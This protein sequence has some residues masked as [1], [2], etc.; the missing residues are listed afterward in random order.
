MASPA[1]FAG[2]MAAFA[3]STRYESLF[4]MTDRELQKRGYDRGGLQRSFI[5]GL[6]GY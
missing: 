6:I 4:S 1:W 5:S 3:P 2:F